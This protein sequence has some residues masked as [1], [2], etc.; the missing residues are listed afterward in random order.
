LQEEKITFMSASKVKLEIIIDADL[1]RDLE[2]LKALTSHKNKNLKDVIQDLTAQELNRR[3]Q[4]KKTATTKWATPPVAAE[5]SNV[6]YIPATI[7]RLV[8]KRDNG[9]CSFVDPLTNK[10]C[11]STYH[12]Q[13]DHILPFAL[14]GGNDAENL[15]LLCANHNRLKAIEVYGQAKMNNYLE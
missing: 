13:L 14:G 2:S 3:S 15:R 6:R 11:E 7:R 5:R 12:L 8:W 10:R 9:Q 1:L 4:S